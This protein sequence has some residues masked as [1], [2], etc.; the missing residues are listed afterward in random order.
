[1]RRSLRQAYQAPDIGVPSWIPQS[2][3]L[4]ARPIW[5]MALYWPGSATSLHGGRRLEQPARSG[6]YGRLL[7]ARRGLRAG[8]LRGGRRSR[9]ERSDMRETVPPDVAPLIRAT[10]PPRWLIGPAGLR[11]GFGFTT[12]PGDIDAACQISRCC[13]GVPVPFLLCHRPTSPSAGPASGDATETAC[14]GS[15]PAGR[16][17]PLAPCSGLSQRHVVRP[18][19]RRPQA[20]GSGGRRLAARAGR[21]RTLPRLRPKHRQPRPRPARVRPGVQR[22]LT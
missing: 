9:H 13:R 3:F 18:L 17:S 15:R 21:G 19:P 16:Q 7:C 4:S 14:P 20:A 6:R 11:L 12:A 10:R 22:V 5:A 2:P 1:M 8:L